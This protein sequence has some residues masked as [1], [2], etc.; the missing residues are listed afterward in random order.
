MS[1][2]NEHQTKMQKIRTITQS[3]SHDHIHTNTYSFGQPT[4]NQLFVFTPTSS[5]PQLERVSAV[6]A[7]ERSC[8]HFEYIATVE[9]VAALV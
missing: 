2:L 9:Y 7:E 8:A 6:F 1:Q 3:R 5:S 4:H